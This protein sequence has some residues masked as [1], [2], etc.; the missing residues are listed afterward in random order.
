MAALYLVMGTTT[1]L[2]F[3]RIPPSSKRG[4]CSPTSP[5]LCSSCWWSHPASL[6]GGRVPRAGWSIP[7]PTCRTSTRFGPPRSAKAG[8]VAA[9]ILNYE[10]IVA[11]LPPNSERQLIEQIVSRLT[12]GSPHRTLYQGD[13]GIFAWFEE[14]RPPF[15][16]HL[17]ALFSLFRNP[18]RV[19]GLSIDLA[20]AFGVE[21]GS[22]RRSR[23]GWPARS[24]RPKRP[25]TTG[26]N[27][28]ITIPRRSRTRRGS[29][30]C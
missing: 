24:S 5:R 4:W 21:V 9:R 19:A 27:G 18:A 3:A 23:T 2:L 14:P 12:V 20:I 13:G 7:S 16:N 25:R 15:G 30:R 1:S 11:T 17:D 29:C 6:A 22:G 26:S 8:A 10:E 28:N